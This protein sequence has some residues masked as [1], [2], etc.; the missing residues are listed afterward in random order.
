MSHSRFRFLCRWWYHDQIGRNHD[1]RW[2]DRLNDKHDHFLRRDH[3]SGCR[4]QKGNTLRKKKNHT[5]AF[6]MSF[7]CCR[8][9]CWYCCW[10][11]FDSLRDR[12]PNGRGGE[13]RGGEGRGRKARK[14]KGR[15]LESR[16][17][18]L[19][20]MT[21]FSVNFSVTAHYI[22]SK[23]RSFMQCSPIRVTVQIFFR[24]N[25]LLKFALCRRHKLKFS[26]LSCGIF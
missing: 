10:V 11:I 21:K 22:Y 26:I 25:C 24:T 8:C 12:S 14:G 5:S 2:S 20:H 7:C 15:D 9:Y 23:I 18:Q 1:Y 17:R 16:L 4:T 3:L 19:N 13:G 6:S